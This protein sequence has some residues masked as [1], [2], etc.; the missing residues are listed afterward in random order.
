R[1]VLAVSGVVALV[2]IMFSGG[3]VW[4]LIHEQY[5]LVLIVAAACLVLASPEGGTGMRGTGWL[6]AMGRASYEIYLTQ[7]FVVFALVGVA[8]MS[9]TDKAWGW[10]WYAPALSLAW[11][12]GYAVA[13][14]FSE[15]ADRW[16]RRRLLKP[17]T[18]PA[19]A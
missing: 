14:Y 17:A 8:R 11:A 18:A 1:R 6:Q 16:L 10:I 13:R 9:G 15:P 3:W 5:L 4:R 19:V 2:A 12:L 7:M